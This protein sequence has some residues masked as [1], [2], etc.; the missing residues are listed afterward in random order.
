VQNI[1]AKYTTLSKGN[2]TQA[3]RLIAQLQSY[4]GYRTRVPASK[5][6]SVNFPKKVNNPSIGDLAKDRI[7]RLKSQFKS[8]FQPKESQL[9]V[10]LYNKVQ[11]IYVGYTS[12]SSNCPKA[13]NMVNRLKKYIYNRTPVPAS[14][15]YSVNFPNKVNNPTIGDLA[16]DRIARLKSQFKSCFASGVTSRSDN[17]YNAIQN[18]YIQYRSA[19]CTQAKEMIRKIQRYRNETIAVPTSKAYSVNYPNKVNNPSIGDLAKDR[20]ARLRNQFKS[21][22]E[23]KEDPQSIR[24]YDGVQNVYLKSRNLASNDCDRA[25]NLVGQLNS[26]APIT[27][28]LVPRSKA[29]TVIYPSKVNN[30][31]IGH[32]A[33]DRIERIKK[34]APDCFNGDN[35][36][37]LVLRNIPGTYQ[38]FNH[39]REFQLKID[40][41]GNSIR[42]SFAKH[43]YSYPPKFKQAKKISNNGVLLEFELGG[44]YWVKY[45]VFY[46]QSGVS[47]YLAESW[48]NNGVLKNLG[49]LKRMNGTPKPKPARLKNVNITFTNQ[50]KSQAFVYWVNNGKEVFYKKLKPN[51]TYV[52]GT[53]SSHRW[54]VKVNNRTRLNYTATRDTSQLIRIR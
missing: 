29:Y 47:A 21:C 4:T 12:A 31:N 11:T 9:S 48:T 37:S 33:K 28:Y 19:N 8:C 36:S 54:R 35:M 42:A 49:V 10:S 3:K 14:K 52:Q 30:P 34:V 23:P 40:R 1:Y 32:L 5:A 38:Y 2:C 20:I 18:I 16:K 46:N 17:M 15:A 25:K 51:Q 43:G 45:Q 26:Y 13:K 39:S 44:S 27:S 22:L 53:Y 50:T 24:Y 41:V 6:Y 7:A